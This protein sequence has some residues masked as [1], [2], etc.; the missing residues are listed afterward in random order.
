MEVKK[1]RK[2]Y[3]GITSDINS[4]NKKAY[5]RF[6]EDTGRSDISYEIFSKIPGKVHEGMIAKM[7][8]GNYT[9]KIPDFGNLKILKVTPKLKSHAR[10]DWGRYNKTGVWA[11]HRNTHSDGK[12]YKVHFYTYNKKYVPLGFFKFNLSRANQRLLSSKILN[13]ELHR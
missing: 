11:P 2:V 13:N 9:I 10:I 3:R 8:S 12:I 4:S 1:Q 6:L 5:K 7:I